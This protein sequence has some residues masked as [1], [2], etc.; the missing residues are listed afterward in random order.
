M[1]V[2]LGPPQ[3]G[4]GG[5][6]E[7]QNIYIYFMHLKFNSIKHLGDYIGLCV[8]PVTV[9]SAKQSFTKLKL[10]QTFFWALQWHRKD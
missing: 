6:T 5:V 7:G 1:V 9:A 8:I 2:A 3:S 10:T 4:G